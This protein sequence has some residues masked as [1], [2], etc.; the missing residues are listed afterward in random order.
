MAPKAKRHDPRDIVTPYAFTVTRELLGQ[1]LAGPV[2]RGVAMV[3][4]LGLLSAVSAVTGR[5]PWGGLLLAVA[6]AIV[7][8]R[9]A[10]GPA[11]GHPLSRFA[12]ATFGCLGSLVLFVTIIALWAT[13][14][15]R[16]TPIR[17][18]TGPGQVQELTLGGLGSAAQQL[19]TE[20]AVL[21]TVQSERERLEAAAAI[22]S[23]L[24][25][26]GVPR[27][28]MA[29]ALESLEEGDT[30]LSPQILGA[31]RAALAA[32]EAV[33]AA[34]LEEAD[35]LVLRYAGALAADDTVTAA[36]LRPQL[37][38]AL[39]GHRIEEL[40]ERIRDLRE[41]NDELE[42]DLEQEREDPG[43]LRVL[44]AIADDLGVGVGWAALYFTVFT[45]LWRGQTPGK[46]LLGIR[47]VRLDG[48]PISWWAAFERF[49]GYAA[50]LATGLLG[51][52]Q[53]LWDA[54]RQAVHD[55]IASTVVLHL[56]KGPTP[57]GSARPTV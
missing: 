20:A 13:R 1:P 34:H 47:V 53:I 10:T 5:T 15:V 2:R 52:F 35:S 56:A 4:D 28:A 14:L 39:A 3:V 57:P 11:R 37:A 42:E 55:K 48:E 41:R 30:A 27:E 32:V 18:P 50:G 31:L 45:T 26:M 6:A 44:K 43:I 49:G 51:F 21:G 54:N 9:I 46:R 25:G 38:E 7:L 17:I 36:L 33:T 16:E 8:F 19:V 12:R 24:S 23:R 22:V 29:G 40:D